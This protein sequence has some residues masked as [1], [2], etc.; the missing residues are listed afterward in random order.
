VT[1]EAPSRLL[2]KAAASVTGKSLF[3]SASP[4]DAL[5]KTGWQQ[6]SVLNAHRSSLIETRGHV[7]NLVLDRIAAAAP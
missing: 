5:R 4:P 3:S 1:C 7:L 2:A 6:P